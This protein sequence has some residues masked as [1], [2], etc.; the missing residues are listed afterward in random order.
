LDNHNNIGTDQSRLS[1]QFLRVHNHGSQVIKEPVS[2]IYNHHS[3]K[4]EH[5]NN[6]L[7]NHQFFTSS[8]MKAVNPFEVFEVLEVT[9]IL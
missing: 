1:E 8:F 3:Q 6:L 7:Y 9:T 2:D 4:L 5:P